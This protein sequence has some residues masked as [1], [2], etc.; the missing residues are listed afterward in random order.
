MWGRCAATF[1]TI[2]TSGVPE[3]VAAHPPRKL[4]LFDGRIVAETVPYYRCRLPER[5]TRNNRVGELPK[6]R[7][8]SCDDLKI[9]FLAS[10][11]FRF[12]GVLS[13]PSVGPKV[14][15]GEDV[16]RAFGNSVLAR[17]L[18]DALQPR[19]EVFAADS[20][21]VQ[22]RAIIDIMCGCG[23]I[24]TFPKVTKIHLG[25]AASAALERQGYAT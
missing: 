22:Q 19:G 16:S 6:D 15:R 3:A 14:L 9:A 7:Q 21:Q 2:A 25:W 18:A 1:F 20:L 10:H 4:V 17:S 5:P 12:G 24:P 11:K 8:L 13:R 23:R